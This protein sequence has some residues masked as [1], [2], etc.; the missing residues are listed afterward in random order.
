MHIF[1][2]LLAATALNFSF[3]WIYKKVIIRSKDIV[4]NG[5][6]DIVRLSSFMI[7]LLLSFFILIFF[8]EEFYSVFPAPP[9]TLIG[10]IPFLVSFIYLGINIK[11]LK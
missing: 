9:Y 3:A 2:I 6:R 11:H 1:F 10:T 7:L 8:Q 4:S 5:K